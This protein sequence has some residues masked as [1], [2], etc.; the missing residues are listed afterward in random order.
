MKYV[1]MVA[2][3]LVTLFTPLRSA[4]AVSDS[5]YALNNVSYT[6]DGTSA[7]R[8]APATLD[9][10][11]TYGDEASVTYTLPWDFKYHGITYNQITADTNGNI[12][13]GPAV[14][15]NIPF[16]NEVDNMVP[17]LS[18]WNSDLSSYYSGGVFIQHKSLPERVVIEWQTESYF[19]QGYNQPN[20]FEVVLFPNNDF[21]FDYNTFTAT[22]PWDNGSGTM[23]VTLENLLTTI[24]LTWNYGNVFTLAKQSFLFNA[25]PPTLSINKTGTGTGTVAGSP[26]GI[27][28]GNACSSTFT[29]GSSITLTATPDSNDVFTGWSGGGCS[30]TGACTFTLNADTSVTAQ[31]DRNYSL[32]VIVTGTG[33]GIVTSVPPGIACNADCSAIFA[34]RVTLVASPYEYSYFSGWTNGSCSGT[35]DCL[36][37]MNAD[38]SVTAEFNFDTSHQV[39][40]TGGS[41]GY[42]SSIQN[43][44]DAVADST[45]IKLW[46]TTYN[47]ELTCNRP[48]AVTLQGGYDS[49]YTSIVG[50]VV[51]S[52]SLTIT[53][54]EVTADGL[55]IW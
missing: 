43:A 20:N 48:V 26:T 13:F 53:D 54:G 8:T 23:G 14:G 28:C 7:D 1:I 52:G 41:S 34:D 6:W 22:T 10:D 30:G 46:A 32:N 36:L 29:P 12:W 27:S 3:A 50:E 35:G 37:T 21:R 33:T 16:V 9:Y 47:E 45:T 39:Q 25:D 55:V 42:Y 11:Y 31:F 18:V 44:Y 19:D 40:A 5:N 38:S 4:L 17:V 2:V 51:L 49:G 15:T 24:S